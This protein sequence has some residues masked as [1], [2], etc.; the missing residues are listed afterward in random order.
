MPRSKSHTSPRLGVIFIGFKAAKELNRAAEAVSTSSNGSQSNGTARRRTSTVKA[1]FP[2]RVDL[3]RLPAPG[4]PSL[5][6][7]TSDP[8][9][10]RTSGTAWCAATRRVYRFTSFLD[11]DFTGAISGNAVSGC[12]PSARPQGS[13]PTNSCQASLA[14]LLEP[15]KRHRILPVTMAMRAMR[16]FLLLAPIASDWGWS[17]TLKHAL[18]ALVAP[19]QRALHHNLEFCAGK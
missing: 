6:G 16:G 19:R 12:L 18:P 10:R 3:R 2:R 17:Q 4:Y 15:G 5:M 11:R 14:R 13:D 7:R 8:S 9:A 1:A